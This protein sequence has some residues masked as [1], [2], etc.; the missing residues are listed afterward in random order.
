MG[1]K[2]RAKPLTFD[3]LIHGYDRMEVGSEIWEVRRYLL[4]GHKAKEFKMGITRGNYLCLKH[5][6]RMVLT[7]EYIDDTDPGYKL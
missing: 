5:K 3:D 2:P 1:G 6:K 7:V 4:P